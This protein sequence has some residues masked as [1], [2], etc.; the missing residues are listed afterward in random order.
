MVNLCKALFFLLN[1]KQGFIFGK[2]LIG[3]AETG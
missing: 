1:E 2:R 3:T